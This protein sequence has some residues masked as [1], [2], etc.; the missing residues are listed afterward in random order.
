M[1]SIG[2]NCNELKRDYDACFNSWFAE[3]FLRGNTNDSACASLFKDYQQ[4][5]KVIVFHKFFI[6]LCF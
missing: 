5:V 2:E 6:R 3:K 1:N 4:C